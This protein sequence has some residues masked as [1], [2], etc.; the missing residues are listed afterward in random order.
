MCY[1][2][3]CEFMCASALLCL[4]DT[5]SMKIP[6]PLSLRIFFP[7]LLHRLLNFEGEGCDK[8]SHLRL[9]T[10]KSFTLVSMFSTDFHVNDNLLQVEAS[11]LMIE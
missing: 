3:L 8:T 2:S 7:S 5:V 1:Y 4:G 9:N 10:L 6:T 11:L